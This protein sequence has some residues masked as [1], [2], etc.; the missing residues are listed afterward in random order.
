MNKIKKILNYFRRKKMVPII[1]K[2]DNT[3]IL[4]DKVALIIGGSGGIGYSIAKKYISAGCKVVLAGTNPQKLEKLSAKLGQNCKYICIDL[5]NISEF[6]SK[7]NDALSCFGKID[8][9]V[10]SAGI[11]IDR[12]DLDFINTTEE[13][14]DKIMNINLKAIYFVSQIIAKYW[15]KNKIEGH[16]LMISSQSALEPPWSPYRLSKNILKDLTTGIAQ[17]LIKYNIVV[18]GI[19]P[20]PS[21]TKMQHYHEGD[22]ISND[23][24]PIG[25]YTMPEEIAEFAVLL[26]SDLGNTIVGDTIYMSGGR[27]IIEMR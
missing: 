11:H 14:Y 10:N 1:V 25:R 16:I 6:E 12:V 7:I 8:I 22:E 27:G 4:K 23:L 9:L 3:N 26:V 21:A 2:T 13:E 17:K 15:I 20:G 24:N 5:N 18:N 19:G